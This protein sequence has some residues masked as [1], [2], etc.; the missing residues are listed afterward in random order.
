MTTVACTAVFCTRCE[1]VL[2]NYE[3]QV[4]IVATNT[5]LQVWPLQLHQRLLEYNTRNEY[6]TSIQFSRREQHLLY[7]S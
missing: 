5:W 6:H 2:G 3:T 4:S 1:V 7:I